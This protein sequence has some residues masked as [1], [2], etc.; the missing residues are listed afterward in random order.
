MSQVVGF[1]PVWVQA[2]Y[3]NDVGEP[4]AGGKLYTYYNEGDTPQTSFTDSTGSIPNTNPIILD[5][6]GRLQTAIWL[7][8]GFYYSLVLHDAEG[9]EIARVKDVSAS[10][11]IAGDNITL[12][13]PSG[14]GP[15]V[16]V[17]AKGAVGNPKGHGQSFLFTARCIDT[18]PAF[19]GTLFTEYVVSSVTTPITVAD[20]V[21]NDY[22]KFTFN[23]A[24]AYTAQ[25]TTKAVMTSTWSGRNAWPAGESVIGAYLQGAMTEKTYHTRYSS[26]PYDGLGNEYQQV[27]FTDTFI[28]NVDALQTANIGVFATNTD[29][30]SATFDSTAQIVITRF[31]PKF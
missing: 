11:L 1:C 29:D 14:I 26:Y 4:L 23:T 8:A 16:T 6:A 27:T 10:L 15:Q 7:S 21:C 19:D 24:G 30:P 3:F 28:I 22:N 13:P 9:T 25:V 18:V 2:Q 31:G 5:S 17:N 20:V 12:D